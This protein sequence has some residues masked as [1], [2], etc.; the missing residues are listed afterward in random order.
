MKKSI[1]LLGI[2]AR[3][4]F[5]V[6]FTYI[7]FALLG[8]GFTKLLWIG[9]VAGLIGIIFGMSDLF[10]AAVWGE[11]DEEP[12]PAPS[13]PPLYYKI[14]GIGGI[15]YFKVYSQNHELICESDSYKTKESCITGLWYLMESMK[16]MDASSWKTEDSN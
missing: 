13:K 6:L 8:L 14:V 7:M 4:I 12:N 1:K 10:E 11:E 15:Y 9:V 16:K 3:L 2:I 5:E